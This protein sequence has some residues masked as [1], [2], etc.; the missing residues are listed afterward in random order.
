MNTDITP[1]RGPSEEAAGPTPGNGAPD[2]AS[3]GVQPPADPE[4]DVALN[5]FLR[6]AKDGTV[7]VI[8]HKSEM[9][10]GVYTA[11]PMLIAEELECDWSR[12]RVEAAPV[13]PVYNNPLTGV[14][15]TGGSMS[16]RTEWEH[17]RTLGAA[18]REMLIGAAAETWQVDRATCRA[19]NGAVVHESGERLLFGELALR[20][21]SLPV[22]EH[23]PLKAPAEFHTRALLANHP[24]H[25]RV[26]DLAAE[27]A[28]WGTPPPEGRARGIALSE[29][30]G[31]FVAEVAEVSVTPAGAV[32]VHRV[33]CAVDCGYTVNPAIVQCQMEGGIVYGLTAALYG[34]ITLH[35]GR[36]DQGNFDDYPLLRIHEMPAVEVYIVPSSE[37]PGGIGEPGTPPIASAVT[38]AL[39]AATGNRIRR[40]PI[41]KDAFRKS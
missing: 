38:N 40:L 11:L 18:V 36:V 27:K 19:E 2:G 3:A 26:L 24:R 9:G 25:R 4:G 13:A 16:V 35:N 21:A 10:Q 34:E 7:T 41:G 20:V 17:L 31:S 12:I 22:P 39:F 32:R 29:S 33:V 14:Q 1:G 37:S 28:G 15:M 6:I 23:P 5:P 8:A 30:F